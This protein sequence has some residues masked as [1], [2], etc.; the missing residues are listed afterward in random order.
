EGLVI[1][2]GS[3]KNDR[4]RGNAQTAGADKFEDT[5]A[6]QPG[7][8]SKRT[9]S[10]GQ[11][12]GSLTNWLNVPVVR[13]DQVWLDHS[14]K[15]RVPVVHVFGHCPRAPSNHFRPPSGWLDKQ[16]QTRV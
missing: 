11:P 6:S 10:G 16:F 15:V 5:P 13:N 14:H 7:P 3:R 1:L 9:R 12:E 8:R 2:K 4:I